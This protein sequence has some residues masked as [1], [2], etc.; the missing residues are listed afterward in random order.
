MKCSADG[1]VE[2][3]GC[4]GIGEG[5]DSGDG[6]CASANAGSVTVDAEA[7]GLGVGD[8]SISAISS[9]IV[10]A[11]IAEA[12]VVGVGSVVVGQGTGAGADFGTSD[13]TGVSALL[14]SSVAA[15]ITTVPT[16]A[17][18]RSLASQIKAG[19]R[20]SRVRLCD[21]P[22]LL[23]TVAFQMAL[24]SGVGCNMPCS[25]ST[26]NTAVLLAGMPSM[27]WDSKCARSLSETVLL[28]SHKASSV[29]QPSE[30][31]GWSASVRA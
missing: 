10:S 23:V 6:G 11:M 20:R 30:A 17:A 14:A 29:S 5:F 31:W 7:S 22:E 4:A 1:V 24:F 12:G 2:V 9:S 19:A 8:G 18:G 3:S 16:N 15:S 26:L 13:D 27:P 28:T 25:C 21:Q